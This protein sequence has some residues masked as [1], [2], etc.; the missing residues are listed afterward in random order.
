MFKKI[1]GVIALIVLVAFLGYC[2]LALSQS[3]G[4]GCVERI[5]KTAID[6][7]Y[8]AVPTGSLT[9]LSK[10]EP[11]ENEDTIAIT[12]YYYKLNDKWYHR[13]GVNYLNRDAYG[14]EL[15]VIKVEK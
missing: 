1:L 13:E 8:Y 14:G 6:P 5:E 10:N 15:K 11:A 12:D 4:C 7:P 9:Y 3:K 2:G